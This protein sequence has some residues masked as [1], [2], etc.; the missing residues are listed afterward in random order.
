MMHITY[1]RYLPPSPPDPPQTPCRINNTHTP[2]SHITIGIITLPD[3]PRAPSTHT[4][5]VLGV[6]DVPCGRSGTSVRCVSCGRKSGGN[7]C[8]LLPFSSHT[9]TANEPRPCNAQQR[10][11]R[12]W[13]LLPAPVH[14]PQAPAHLVCLAGRPGRVTH[15]A[16]AGQ[17]RAKHLRRVH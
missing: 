3:P 5:R 16:A 12:I 4:E 10:V 6:L 13:G 7:G 2:H 15:P 8:F 11:L 9:H 1:T 17:S 14:A